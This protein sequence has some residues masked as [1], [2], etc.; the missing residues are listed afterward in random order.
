MIF[1]LMMGSGSSLPVFDYTGQHQ[2]VDEGRQGNRHNWTLR[3]LTSGVLTFLRNPGDVDV[4][5]VGGGGGGGFYDGG[6]GG[7]GYTTTAYVHPKAKT[8]YTVEVG[9]GGD[10]A[11]S[12]TEASGDGGV[13]SIVETETGEIL[14]SANGGHG[15]GTRPSNVSAAGG[16]GGSGGGC[17]GADSQL[18]GDGGSDGSD[19]VTGWTD[20][21][22]KGQGTTTR[23]FGEPEGQ[24]YA[25]GGGGGSGKAASAGGAGGGGG[26]GYDNGKIA[27]VAGGTNT[28]GG[29]GGG[30]DAGDWRV[31]ADGG[32]G[33]IIIRNHRGVTA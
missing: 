4:F 8:P 30:S 1:N 12:A 23:A 17:G 31:G 25:G 18:G 16:D 14:V 6:G 2:L 21:E 10:G 22:G 27:A 20:K 7:G 11:P 29:G 33:I 24:L 13:T 19:G 28:G 15:G 5:L 3:L 32:S 26:G 9:A